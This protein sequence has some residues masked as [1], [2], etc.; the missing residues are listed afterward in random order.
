MVLARVLEAIDRFS[1]TIVG[2]YPLGLGTEGG[3]L[4]VA[5]SGDLDELERAFRAVG[6]VTR[7]GDAIVARVAAHPAIALTGEHLPVA[8]QRAFRLLAIE[9]RLLTVGG[10]ALRAIVRT[11]LL[12]G[13]TL[14]SAFSLALGCAGEPS[15]ALLGLEHWSP[16]RLASLVERAL[17]PGAPV[18]A[19]YT[20]PRDTL[21]PMFRL[22]DDSDAAIVSYLALGEVWTASDNGATI[23]HVQMVG[24]GLEWELKSL[25]V[26]EERRGGGLG[27]ALVETGLAHAR[28]HGAR[29]IGIATAAAEVDLLRFYQRLGFRF[30]RVERDVFTAGAGYPIDLRVDGIPIR[31][32]VWLGLDL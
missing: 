31:D 4:A 1:P 12:A 18:I 26:I 9:A 29:R 13:D 6:R 3:D 32:R 16:R 20:G 11:R 2:A 5:C 8:A 7:S 19:I 27:R 10:E 15:S 22:A 24:Q 30:E 23:G 25:A 14:E 28:A 17:H 21:W